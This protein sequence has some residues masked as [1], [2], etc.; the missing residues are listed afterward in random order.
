MFNLTVSPLGE[1]IL[2]LALLSFKSS[3]PSTSV[4][5]NENEKLDTPDSVILPDAFSGNTALISGALLPAASIE[6]F[7]VLFPAKLQLLLSSQY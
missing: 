2:I 7:I 5:L 4:A 6:T 3:A 1:V